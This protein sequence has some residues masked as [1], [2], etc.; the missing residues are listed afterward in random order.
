MSKFL[1]RKFLITLAT[2][3]ID[4]LASTGIIHKDL[5]GNELPIINGLTAV[6][7]AVEGIIDAIGKNKTGTP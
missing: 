1:S 6:Y 4:V 3:I 5:I 7:V 2:L